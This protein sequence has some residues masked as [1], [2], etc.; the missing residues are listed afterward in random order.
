LPPS[1]SDRFPVLNPGVKPEAKIG[2][3]AKLIQQ[4]SG[5]RLGV[6]RYRVSPLVQGAAD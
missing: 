6:I 5:G 1:A 4:L 3:N 2:N